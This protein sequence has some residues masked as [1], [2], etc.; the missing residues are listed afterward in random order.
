MESS[1]T[2][3]AHLRGQEQ[4]FGQP[5]EGLSVSTH[6]PAAVSTGAKKAEDMPPIRDTAAGYSSLPPDQHGPE[7]NAKS[8]APKLIVGQESEIAPSHTAVLPTACHLAASAPGCEGYLSAG[9][10]CGGQRTDVAAAE[11]MEEGHSMRTPLLGQGDL[12]V[13]VG[14][15]QNLCDKGNLFLIVYFSFLRKQLFSSLFKA[16]F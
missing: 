7:D 8:T 1:T 6:S 15:E 11:K 4:T 2:S 3:A 10:G 9:H 5:A 13:P 14:T 12:E 16:I